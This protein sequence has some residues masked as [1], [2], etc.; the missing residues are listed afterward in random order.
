MMVMAAMDT[1][2]DDDNQKFNDSEA[3]EAWV[4]PFW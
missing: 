3:G 4:K 2:D 1:N